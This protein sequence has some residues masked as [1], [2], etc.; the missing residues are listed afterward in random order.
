MLGL[1]L[2]ASATWTGQVAPQPFS[3]AGLSSALCGAAVTPMTAASG[4]CVTALS[5]LHCLHQ[6]FGVLSAGS[7]HGPWQGLV[8]CDCWLPLQ[9]LA[10]PPSSHT[11]SPGHT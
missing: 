11:L 3:C 7:W 9:L 2:A 4:S 10:G 1:L 5:L 6:L 8:C